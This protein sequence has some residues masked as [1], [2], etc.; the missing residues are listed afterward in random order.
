MP[1]LKISYV[2]KG[3]NNYIQVKKHEVV[4]QGGLSDN[5]KIIDWEFLWDSQRVIN[6]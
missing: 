1:E 5:A 6:G 4:L 2:L 3:I